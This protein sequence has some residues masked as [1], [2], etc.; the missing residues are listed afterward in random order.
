MDNV[1]SLLDKRAL[2]TGASRGLGACTQMLPDG[3]LRM[4]YG[5]MI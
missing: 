3:H 4:H 1:N 5:A 2:T